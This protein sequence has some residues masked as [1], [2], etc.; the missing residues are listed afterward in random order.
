MKTLVVGASG[1]TGKLLVM[2]LLA[3]GQ[4]V[5]II[6]R[7]TSNI[8]DTWNNNDNITIIRINDISNIPVNE[9]SGYLKDCQS[10]ASCLGHNLSFKGMYGKPKLLITDTVQIICETIIKNAPEKPLRFVL[11]NT[12]GNNNKNLNEPV[13]FGQ[14]IV[15]GLFRLL[16]PPHSDNEN[17]ADYL[18][19]KIGQKNR[20]IEWVT[21][22]PDNLINA[23][24][25]TE[26]SLH[27][28]P[29][30]SALFNPGQTSRINVAH[31]M[32][33]LIINDTIYNKWSGQMPVIYN[34]ITEIK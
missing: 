29:T 8:P 33:Q 17:A 28:S 30:R 5:K 27:A 18:R 1:S 32:S 12:A 25:V 26:Y 24:I 21:V 7:P 14:K 2:Q 20:F 19:V 16:L 34:N 3:A 11:M 4:E 15:I 6:V 9:M 10:V 31:F 22:R 13:S 23:Q